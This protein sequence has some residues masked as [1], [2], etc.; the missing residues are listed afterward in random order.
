MKRLLLLFTILFPLSFSAQVAKND[1][2]LTP[3]TDTIAAEVIHGQDYF[4]GIF[5]KMSV[6]QIKQYCRNIAAHY[7]DILDLC[8]DRYVKVADCV[9]DDPSGFKSNDYIFSKYKDMVSYTE[10]AKNFGSDL[11]P[12]GLEKT[13]LRY[14]MGY[15]G[16]VKSNL[17]IKRAAALCRYDEYCGSCFNKAIECADCIIEYW[18][19]A[20]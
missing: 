13:Y 18:W 2:V 8:K 19:T 4:E 14:V 1:S 9:S 15:S 6:S 11:Y 10:E 3:E 12:N 20:R 7:N 16:K 17:L 5:R